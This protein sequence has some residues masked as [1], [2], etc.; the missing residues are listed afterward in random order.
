MESGNCSYTLKDSNEVL[1][2]R[3]GTLTNN[4]IIDI[5]GYTII[6]LSSVVN[7][8]GSK[9]GTHSSSLSGTNTSEIVGLRIE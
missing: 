5:S 1:A 9:Y 6:E 7:Y 3:T 8:S 4:S 2:Q